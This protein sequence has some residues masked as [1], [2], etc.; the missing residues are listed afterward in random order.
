MHEK[1]WK[2]E[3]LLKRDGLTPHAGAS[4]GD[5]F[6]S[7]SVFWAFLIL[8]GVFS[9][10][11]C[12]L[13]NAILAGYALSSFYSFRFRNYAKPAKLLNP[14]SQ[15]TLLNIYTSTHF[16]GCIIIEIEIIVNIGKIVV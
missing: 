16:S 7:F 2:C 3:I 6:A 9:F 4:A 5:I 15:L 13:E 1:G 8:V 11:P 10:L 14:A 12:S